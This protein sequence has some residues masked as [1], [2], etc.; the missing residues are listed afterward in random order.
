MQECM[1]QYPTVYGKEDKADEAEDPLDDD[2]TNTKPEE[3]S[4]EITT[5][6][7]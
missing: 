3:P 6:S 2:S 7:S 5:L 1:L 4:A